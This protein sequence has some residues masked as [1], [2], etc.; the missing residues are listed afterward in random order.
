[1]PMRVISSRKAVP[2][3]PSEPVRPTVKY[4]DDDDDDSPSPED[5]VRNKF[6]RPKSRALKDLRCLLT[7]RVEV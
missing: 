3:N 5:M 2:I 6:A 4:L 1:V 7:A